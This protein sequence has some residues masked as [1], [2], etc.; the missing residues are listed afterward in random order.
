MNTEGRVWSSHLQLADAF[1]LEVAAC[2]LLRA[3]LC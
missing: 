2:R 1:D 3:D